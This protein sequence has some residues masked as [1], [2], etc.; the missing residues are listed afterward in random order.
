MLVTARSL[1][2]AWLEATAI[3]IDLAAKLASGI[4]KS[5]DVWKF[6]YIACKLLQTIYKNFFC[7]GSVSFFPC[8][9]PL[10]QARGLFVCIICILMQVKNSAYDLNVSRLAMCQ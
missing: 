6:R 5:H 10:V 3:S 2:Y 7:M 8:H 4:E 9:L 1:A